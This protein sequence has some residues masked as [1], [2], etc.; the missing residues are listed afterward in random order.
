VKFIFFNL[1]FLLTGLLFTP[2]VKAQADTLE[3]CQV[4]KGLPNFYKKLRAG[5]SVII[6]YLG[7]SITA[8]GGGWRDQSAD[9][10]QQQYPAAKIRQINAGVGGTGSDLGVFRVQHDVLE[11]HPDL[12][13][14]EFAV[15]D[16]GLAPERIHQAM[17]GIVRQIWRQNNKTDICFVYTLSGNMLSTLQ[18]GRLW[19]SMLA[20]EQVAQHYDIPSVLFGKSIAALVTAGG[21]V[22]QGKVEDYPGKLIFSEDNVHPNTHTGHRLYTEALIRSMKKIAQQQSSFRHSIKKVF[23]ADNWENA[24]MLPVT[25][26]QKKGEWIDLAATADTIGAQFRARFPHLF[27]SND[28]SAVLSLSCAGGIAGMYDV[29]G[30]GCGQYSISIDGAAPKLYPRIDKYGNYYRSAYF[31]FPLPG[32]GQHT[33]E[34]KVSGQQPDKKA[35][36]KQGGKEPGNDPR[37]RENACYAGWLLILKK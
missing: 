8:A 4:R 29:M 5:D 25:G 18:Q 16:G 35:L 31:L 28:T 26:V 6:G 10:F 13:F 36:L 12:V 15:N 20:M 32:N 21:L 19:S 1:F 37:Y 11:E 30:P 14:V 17:E 2:L 23:T 7:G 27:K 22:F 33:V 34:W 3:E 9:W 24:Q